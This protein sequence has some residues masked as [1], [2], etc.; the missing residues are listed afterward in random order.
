MAI[1][2]LKVGYISRSSGRS[3]V[4]SAAYITGEKLKESRRDLTCFYK[5]KISDV[6]FTKT[7]SLYANADLSIWDRLETFEDV[8]ASQ[9]FLSDETQQKYINSAQTAMTMVIALPKELPLEESR[10]LVEDF[11]SKRFVAR[12]LVVTYALHKDEGNPHAH[13]QISRR[14]LNAE[15]EISWIK[16]REIC[17]KKALLVRKR[18][19]CSCFYQ[20]TVSKR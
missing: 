17:T 19:S 9:R 20:S 11:A 2:H 15:G 4:Q 16:D 14:S 12:G 1:Y 8:Y 3:S 6:G 18:R 5:N 13:L 10:D 7:L